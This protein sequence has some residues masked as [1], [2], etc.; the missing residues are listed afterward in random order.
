[1]DNTFMVVLMMIFVAIVMWCIC[2][3]L[4]LLICSISDKERITND[5]LL[6]SMEL[7]VAL[8]FGSVILLI[9]GWIEDKKSDG[10]WWI[11]RMLN[12]LI[13]GEK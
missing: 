7:G 6:E 10:D 3:I 8:L 9:L 4:G 11:V 1:M 2:G 12:K 13:G 5:K